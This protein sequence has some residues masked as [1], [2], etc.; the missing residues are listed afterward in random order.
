VDLLDENREE[1]IVLKSEFNRAWDYFSA[2]ELG[3]TITEAWHS[4]LQEAESGLHRLSPALSLDIGDLGSTDPD[5][6]TE[7]VSDPSLPV[8]HV[9][10]TASIPD[11]RKLS[12]GSHARW[13]VSRRRTLQLKDLVSHWKRLVLHQYSADANSQFE[14][15]EGVPPLKEVK[16][17]QLTVDSSIIPDPPDVESPPQTP[18]AAMHHDVVVLDR[19]TLMPAITGRRSPSEHRSRVESPETRYVDLDD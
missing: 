1:V 4:W 12:F 11:I 16:Q 9:F 5:L 8:G 15:S 19:S 14:W 18:R 13:L 17:P 2:N 7:V 6:L 3:K 10:R